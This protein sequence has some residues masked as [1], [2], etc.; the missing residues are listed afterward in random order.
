MRPGNE[1]P[2]RNASEGISAST[3]VIPVAEAFPLAAGSILITAMRGNANLAGSEDKVTQ[4]ATPPAAMKIDRK[5][6][7]KAK[8]E[9]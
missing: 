9:I 6:E 8:D 4:Y 1:I 5:D 7:Q 3:F 2:G